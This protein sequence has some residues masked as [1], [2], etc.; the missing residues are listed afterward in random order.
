MKHI[1]P[2]ISTCDKNT[3]IISPKPIHPTL[4]QPPGVQTNPVNV[5]LPQLARPKLTSSKTIVGGVSTWLPPSNTVFRSPQIPKTPQNK[6]EESAAP[7]QS[8]VNMNNKRYIVVPK[9][10]V[11][12]VSPN[13]NQ[14]PLKPEASQSTTIITPTPTS[15]II[16]GPP[17]QNNPFIQASNNSPGV[18]LVPYMQN[19]ATPADSTATQQFLI[20]NPLPGSS[21]TPSCAQPDLPI[22]SET[23]DHFS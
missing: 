10:N 12:S 2:V 22:G 14:S 15:T 13:Q 4:T 6:P 16:Q 17:L 5:R 18:L 8:I 11:L 7:P 1:T 19:D 9:H 3:P 21:A 23:P 20:V